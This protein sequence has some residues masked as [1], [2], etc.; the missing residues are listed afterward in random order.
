MGRATVVLRV[1][2]IAAEGGDKYHW[3][4][5]EPL[6]VI[7]NDSPQRF[8]APFRVAHYGWKAGIP[9]GESIIYLEPYGDPAAG[10]WRLLEG[11]G[12]V[13]VGPS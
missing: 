8:D 6:E 5:V 12:A 3:D 9:A 2:L 11:D 4:R 7:K 13:G 10:L 1:K